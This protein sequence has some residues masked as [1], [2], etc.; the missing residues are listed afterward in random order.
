MLT[1]IR[2]AGFDSFF[3]DLILKFVAMLLSD[4]SN[5]PATYNKFHL[6]VSLMGCA[7]CKPPNENESMSHIAKKQHVSS[8]KGMFVLREKKRKQSQ[9]KGVSWGGRTWQLVD[10]PF[11]N[12]F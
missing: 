12:C 1:E 5:T 4:F 9:S 11:N 10:I 6:P 3:H 7:D 8:D 2:S